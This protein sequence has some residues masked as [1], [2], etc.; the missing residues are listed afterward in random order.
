MP[1]QMKR[2]PIWVEEVDLNDFALL[3]SIDEHWKVQYENSKKYLSQKSSSPSFSLVERVK[4][5]ENVHLKLDDLLF[6]L[7]DVNTL[8][9]KY[10]LA[11][12]AEIIKQAILEKMNRG[13]S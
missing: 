2:I 3:G 6:S 10:L 9:P 1:G 8:K 12:D 13:N 11:N 7:Q 4:R 5:I